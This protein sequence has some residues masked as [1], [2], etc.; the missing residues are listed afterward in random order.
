MHVL[1]CSFIGS[2]LLLTGN[3][4]GFIATLTKS[5]SHVEVKPS[6]QSHP[7]STSLAAMK[8]NPNSRRTFLTKRISSFLAISTLSTSL[9]KPEGAY[10]TL[11]DAEQANAKLFRSGEALSTEFALER[12]RLGRKDLID[13]LDNYDSIMAGGGDSVRRYLG[14]VGL[15]SGLYGITKVLKSLQEEA[16]DIVEYTENM[17]EFNAYLNAADTACYSSNFVEHSS[18]KGTPEGYL[19]DAKGDA[20]NMLVYLDRMA[21]ELNL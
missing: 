19:R 2:I 17:N 20:K 1:K 16:E 18:A 6:T 14:T 8:Q 21:K 7:S 15:N 13:L 10:A 9:I 12:F 3:V 11:M 5:I 4:D